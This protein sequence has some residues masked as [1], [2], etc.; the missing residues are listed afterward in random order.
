[1][2]SS[3]H[4]EIHTTD[5]SDIS[6]S[7]K[8]HPHPLTRYALLTLS[9]LLAIAFSFAVQVLVVITLRF[10]VGWAI[11]GPSG[12]LFFIILAFVITSLPVVGA[13]LYWRRRRKDSAEQAPLSI[14]LLVLY[15]LLALATNIVLAQFLLAYLIPGNS[16][17]PVS[18]FSTDVTEYDCV[19]DSIA[20]LKAFYASVGSASLV[21]F[22]SVLVLAGGI[23]GHLTGIPMVIEETVHLTT[24]QCP[25]TSLLAHE[26]THVWQF[27]QSEIFSEGVTGFLE[28]LI[29]QNTVRDSMYDYDLSVD[30]NKRFLDYGWEQQASMVEDAFLAWRSSGVIQEEYGIIKQMLL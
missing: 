5:P 2:P 18:L 29:D 17:L 14:H 16:L 13:W 6:Y 21:D 10:E 24:P 28:W 9:Y 7:D 19:Q 3:Q 25:S 8:V 27:Q 11:H 22:S 12:Y 23:T 1:M 30:V 20:E 26:L 15:Y 4:L